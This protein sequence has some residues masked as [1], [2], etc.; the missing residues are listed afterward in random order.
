[1]SLEGKTA[2]ITGGGRGIGAAVARALAGAGAA[3]ALAARTEPQVEQVADELRAAG[4]VAWALGCDVADPE[5]VREMARVAAARLENVDI[6]VNGAGIAHSAPVHELTLDDWN[7]L[8][9]VNATGTFLCTKVFLPGMLERS[10]GRVIN[11]A[12]VAGL[13]G[14]RYIAGYAAS[15]HAVVGFTRCLAA[16]IADRGV[17][18]NAVCPGYVE[19]AMTQ[20]SLERI[21]ARP[22]RS[23]DDAFQALLQATPQRRLIQPDE[24]AHVVL[25]LCD[26]NARGINGQAI[27]LDGGGLLA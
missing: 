10:W 23:R 4:R 9:A 24:V 19:S 2:V 20:E 5:S 25:S 15:K 21:V 27:V 18:A 16:E 1:M 14:A 17:T 8:L 26:D 13:A 6:L 3:V 22:G 7:R 12:S 11:I